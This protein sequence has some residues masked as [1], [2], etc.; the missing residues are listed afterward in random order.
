MKDFSGEAV[1]TRGFQEGSNKKSVGGTQMA[2][3]SGVTLGSRKNQPILECKVGVEQALTSAEA[4]RDTRRIHQYPSTRLCLAHFWISRDPSIHPTTCNRT[5]CIKCSKFVGER[6]T[7]SILMRISPSQTER[8]IGPCN[9]LSCFMRML[10]QS[11]QIR[12]VSS[13]IP[14]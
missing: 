7:G 2:S 13:S 5:K 1:I 11:V 8:S 9:R 4:R 12:S 14:A 3:L 10:P 6:L